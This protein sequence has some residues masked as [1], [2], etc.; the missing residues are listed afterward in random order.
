MRDVRARMRARPHA[1][2]AR[3]VSAWTGTDGARTVD[4]VGSVLC[5][6]ADAIAVVGRDGSVLDWNDAAASTFA[7]GVDRRDLKLPMLFAPSEHALVRALVERALAE[8]ARGTLV[9][10]RGDAS[11]FVA[12]VTLRPLD[13]LSPGRSV[14]TARDA[15]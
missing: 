5:G 10:L 1:R 7:I 11:R 15:T 2:V 3:G 12:E 13:G 4:E 14:L 9:A 6:E 8:Q